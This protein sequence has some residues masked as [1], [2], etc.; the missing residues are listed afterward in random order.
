MGEHCQH[1][2]I[3]MPAVATGHPDGVAAEMSDER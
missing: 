1:S 2:M 3:D